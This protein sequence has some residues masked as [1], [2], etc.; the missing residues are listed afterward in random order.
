MFAIPTQFKT[1]ME[2]DQKI[3][4]FNGDICMNM[5]KSVQDTIFQTL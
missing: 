2:Q 3:K 1:A 5:P 4:L